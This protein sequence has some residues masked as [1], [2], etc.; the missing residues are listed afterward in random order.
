MAVSRHPRP[1]TELLWP[2]SGEILRRMRGGTRGQWTAPPVALHPQRCITESQSGRRPH[3]EIPSITEISA[4][5][6]MLS[7]VSVYHM[8]QSLLKSDPR[9]LSMVFR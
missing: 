3:P 7:S 5:R 4:H 9:D 8:P 1:G 6:V 2:H